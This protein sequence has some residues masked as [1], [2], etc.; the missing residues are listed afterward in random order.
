MDWRVAMPKFSE[1]E[2]SIIQEKLLSDGERL[3]SLHGIRK[4]TV[5]DLVKAAG[6]AKG[7]FYAFYSS[8]EHL[9]MDILGN[10]QK[11][12]WG[13]LDAFLKENSSLAPREL[14]KQVILFSFREI[15]KY[16]LLMQQDAET[17]NYLFRKLPKDVIDAHTVDDKHE[18]AKLTEYGV[19]F[20]CDL[21]LAARTLQVLAIT[22]FNL[23]NNSSDHA[24]VMEILLNGVINEIVSD[25]ND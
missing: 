8:K 12:I 6:I 1:N 15:R 25:N 2:K 9:Y 16:P 24:D 21:E 13:N 4:V 11:N 23:Q 22:F 7:S 17:T 5:D 3:F 18:L 14:T 10:L 20:K 19:M